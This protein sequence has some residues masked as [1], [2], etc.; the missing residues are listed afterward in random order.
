MKT[1]VMGSPGA[2]DECAQHVLMEKLKKKQKK[3]IATVKALLSSE[4]C[5]YLS[6]FSTKTY[7]VGTH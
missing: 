7:V 4:K 3:N 6:Y 1:Y 5:W 2:S